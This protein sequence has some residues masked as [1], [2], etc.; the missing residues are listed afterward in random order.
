MANSQGLSDALTPPKTQGISV[1][2]SAPITYPETVLYLLRALGLTVK[3]SFPTYLH[4]P[5]L[6][7][8]I[9]HFVCFPIFIP[10]IQIYV[11]YVHVWIDMVH[12][13]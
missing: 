12:F 4:D 5:L 2:L 1:P 8:Y 10:F 6:H 9:E 7:L 3:I 11:I 13:V